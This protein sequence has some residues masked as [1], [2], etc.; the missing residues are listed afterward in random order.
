MENCLHI[1]TIE[2]QKGVRATG[3]KEVTFF[4]DREIRLRLINGATLKIV[5][6]ELKITGFDDKNGT[7]NALGKVL[8]ST[9]KSTENILKKV[10]K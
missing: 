4:N 5:G 7:F 8:G 2:N 1:L 6:E 10:L 3:V 9:Y